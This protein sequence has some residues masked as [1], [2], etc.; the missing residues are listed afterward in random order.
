MVKPTKSSEM[1]KVH[2][3]EGYPLLSVTLKTILEAQPGKTVSGQSASTVQLPNQIRKKC[4]RLFPDYHLLIADYLIFCRSLPKTFQE[5]RITL[6]F[7]T[8]ELPVSSWR[9]ST[10]FHSVICLLAVFVFAIF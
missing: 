10:P 2:L 1:F 6:I 3:A 9:C 4:Y 5:R 8:Y 7:G